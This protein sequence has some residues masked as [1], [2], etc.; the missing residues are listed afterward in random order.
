MASRPTVYPVFGALEDLIL[1]VLRDY[2][3][4]RDDVH[5]YDRYSEGMDLPAVVPLS[6]NRAG[7]VAY[8]TPEDSWA[9]SGIIELNTFADGPNRDIVASQLQE[10]CRHA[11]YEAFFK[12]TDYPGLG[13]I[14]KVS[15][16]NYSRPEGDWA[17]TTHAVQYAR[18]PNS[19][20]RY[21]ARYRLLIRP[22][23]TYSNPFLSVP[24]GANKGSSELP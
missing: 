22:S 23:K 10:A 11:I 4:D 15:N 7:M 14:N 13:V 19:V 17:T 21:E 1:A 16:S 2:F 3:K 9:R 18:L 20:T 8:Q 5:I 6:A 24:E 12:Q